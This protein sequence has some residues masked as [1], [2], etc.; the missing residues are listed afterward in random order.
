MKK[1]E[2]LSDSRRSRY[3]GNSSEDKVSAWLSHAIPHC[4]VSRKLRS[5]C[6]PSI[7]K[8]LQAFPFQRCEAAGTAGGR[9]SENGVAVD[10]VQCEHHVFADAHLVSPVLALSSDDVATDGIGHVCACA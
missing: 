7:W 1:M 4:L 6:G 9:W 10:G 8:P 5:S 2:A 3:F